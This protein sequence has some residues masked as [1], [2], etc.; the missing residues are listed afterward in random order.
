LL[1]PNRDRIQL[2][3]GVWEIDFTGYGGAYLGTDGTPAP[4]FDNVAFKVFPVAGPVMSAQDATLAQ[5]SFPAG[6]TI[7]YSNLGANSVRFDAAK[8]ISPSNHGV[9][10]D[11]GDSILVTVAPVRSGATLV[12]APRLHWRLRRNPLF[13]AYRSATPSNPTAGRP[14]YDSYGTLVANTWNFDLPDTGFMY[15]GDVLHYFIKAQDTV[16]GNVGTSFVPADTVGFSL[17]PGDLDY[18]RL[19]Y[20]QVWTVNALPSVR[21]TS[22]TSQ[23]RILLWYDAATGGENEWITALDGLGYREGREYDV[24]YTNQPSSNFGNGLGGRATGTQ[25]SGY[26]TMLYTSGDQGSYVLGNGDSNNPGNDIGLLSSWLGSGAKNLFCTGDD[27]AEDLGRR[28]PTGTYFRSDWL[29]I[30]Y[31]NA[32]VAASIGD[33]NTAYVIPV[34]GNAVGLAEPFVA[35]GG[36]PS[37][38]DFDAVTAGTSAIRIAEFTNAAGAPNYSYAAGL[39]NLQYGSRIISFPFDFMFVLEHAHKSLADVLTY[40]GESPQGA[41]SGVPD[42]N[43]SSARTAALEQVSVLIVPDGTGTTISESIPFLVESP[44]GSRC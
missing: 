5:D 26:R 29:G 9:R 11:P 32:D 41:A 39:L 3:L 2:A 17:F 31:V 27:L 30:S 22:Q 43:L 4:Y 7:N 15:P 36:C 8:D 24:Y 35:D 12:E 20:P 6:G 25:I 40:F 34:S 21:G 13:D 28:G 14:T 38:N 1:L 19:Q 10:N 33:Q 44:R 18:V 16:G 42:V 23:P 37:Y